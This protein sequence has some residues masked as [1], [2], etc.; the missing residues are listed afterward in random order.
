[1]RKNNA[2]VRIILWL[3]VGI[4]LISF[5]VN[6]NNHNFK[7]FDFMGIPFG[8][9]NLSDRNARN[10][11]EKNEYIIE[12]ENIDTLKFDLTVDEVVIEETDEKDIKIIERSNYKLEEDQKLQVKK[13]DNIVEIIRYEKNILSRQRNINRRIE[14]FIPKSYNKNLIIS[15][16]V[17][18]IKINSDFKL[19]EFKISLDVGDVNIN[20]YMSCRAFEVISETGD[21]DIESIDTESYSIESNVGDIDINSITGSGSIESDIGNINCVIDEI[22]GNVSIDS[23]TGDVDIDV[24]KN[25]SFNLYSK[26]GVGD[27]KS[28]LDFD[29]YNNNKKIIKGSIGKNPSH[30]IDIE[31]NVGD[32]RI[33]SK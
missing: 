11:S 2:I 33:N 30:N 26:Y 19:D 15:S 16:N 24:N 29:N 21:I 4:M 27:F 25:L 9:F 28:N 1:M 13:N 23:N 18:D 8:Y 20:S 6:S 32:L 7:Y 12:L 14:V 10:L 3:V 5:L 31:C 17:G 22:S